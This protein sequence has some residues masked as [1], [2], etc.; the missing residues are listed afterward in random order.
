MRKYFYGIVALVIALSLGLAACAAPAAPA[1][2]PTPAPGPSTTPAPAPSPGTSREQQLVAAAKANGEDKVVFWTMTI[3][4]PDKIFKPFEDKYGIRVISWDAPSGS[5]VVPKMIAE[6][7][8]GRYTPDVLILSELDFPDLLETGMMLEYDFP[9]VDEGWAGQPDSKFYRNINISLRAPMYNTDLVSEAEAPKKW[10]DLISSRWRGKA[11]VSSSCDEC[12]LI[13]AYHWRNKETGALDWDRAFKFWGDV[14][15]TTK[16][17]VGRGFTTPTQL[18]VAGDVDIFLANSLNTGMRNIRK[19]AP[20]AVAQVE[21]IL[22]TSW[23]IG[24]PK[25]VPHPNAAKLLVDYLTS[26]EGLFT[27]ADIQAGSPPVERVSKRLWGDSILRSM[28]IGIFPTPSSL[29]TVENN[30]KSA[31]WWLK[32]IGA[33]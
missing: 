13:F 19:G 33:R 26:D 31:E 28:G 32:A 14:I 17:N 30:R 22:G 9:N 12:P 11:L 25:T 4:E 2:A 18:L 6:A 29:Y 20:I 23:A 21:F 16:P 5:S 10:D 24:I 27:Y 1:P 15:E 8:V 7:K 3:K